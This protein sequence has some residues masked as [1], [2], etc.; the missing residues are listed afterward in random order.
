MRDGE[1]LKLGGGGGGV[2]EEEGGGIL[3][4]KWLGEGRLD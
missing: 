3:S 1:M 4:I 2:A